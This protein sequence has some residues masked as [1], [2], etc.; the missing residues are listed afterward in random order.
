M[1]VL[2][3]VGEQVGCMLVLARMS[4]SA[5][6]SANHVELVLSSGPVIMKQ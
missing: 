1:E 2:A 5:L 6:E 4:P 3:T